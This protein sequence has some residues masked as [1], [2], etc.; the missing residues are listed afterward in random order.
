MTHKEYDENKW[1]AECG[2]F[3]VSSKATSKRQAEPKRR[4]GK[5]GA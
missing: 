1:Q 5:D 3:Q 2:C 4:K